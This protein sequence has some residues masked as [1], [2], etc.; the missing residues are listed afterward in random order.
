MQCHSSMLMR[1]HLCMCFQYMS[2]G[3]LVFG[4]FVCFIDNFQTVCNL[5][6]LL[7]VEIGDLSVPDTE[8]M[9]CA[10]SPDAQDHYRIC[11]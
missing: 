1:T 3:E 10:K 4:P 7:F 5:I 11:S 6:C 2:G 9:H 8:N